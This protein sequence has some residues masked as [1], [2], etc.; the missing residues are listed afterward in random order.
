[1]IEILA[2]KYCLIYKIYV[3]IILLYRFLN[4]KIYIIYFTI[5][6]NNIT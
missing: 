5:F 3:F 4:E 1:M 2:K 6:K